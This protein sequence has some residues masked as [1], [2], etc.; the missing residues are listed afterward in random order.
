MA[1]A[2][3]HVDTCVRAIF[4]ATAEAE[5]STSL[6]MLQPVTQRLLLFGESTRIRGGEIGR[7]IIY[8]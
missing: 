6:Q 3:W 2:T 7:F 8:P 4:K 5:A 1:S